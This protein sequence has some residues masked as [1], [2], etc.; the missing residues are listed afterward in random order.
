MDGAGTTEL[1][2]EERVVDES[3]VQQLTG[4]SH[5]KCHPT[6][7]DIRGG[8]TDIRFVSICARQGATAATVAT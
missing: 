4:T 8:L 5:V 1:N 6:L 3:S 2:V 7:T